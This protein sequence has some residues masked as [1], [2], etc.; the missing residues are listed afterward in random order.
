MSEDNKEI[1]PTPRVFDKL[2]Q[3]IIVGSLVVYGSLLGRSAALRVGQVLK[4]RALLPPYRRS[5]DEIDWRITVQGIDDDS[6][7]YE[8]GRWTGRRIVA[9]CAH[10]GTLMFPTRMIVVSPATIP[11]KYRQLLGVRC[12]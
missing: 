9:L 11:L 5:G 8:N 7:E 6:F 2:G 1:V 12:W 10:K 4:L 3:E